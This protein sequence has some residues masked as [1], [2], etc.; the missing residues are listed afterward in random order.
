MTGTGRT[1]EERYF[2]GAELYGDDLTGDGLEAWFE[3]ER[4]GYADL[5]HGAGERPYEYHVLNDLHGWRHLPPGPLGDVL[6]VGSAFGLEFET[7]ADRLGTLTI[8]EPSAVLRSAAV[9]G[10]PVTYV[11]PR[12]SG[13]LTFA[14]GS[15]DLTVG[16]G[17]LHH[18]PNVSHVF[19][20]MVRV[21]RTGG[22]IVVREPIVSMGDWRRPRPGL[23]RHE[24]GLPLPWFRSLIAAQDVRVVHEGLCMFPVTR[25]LHGYNSPVAVRLD[26]AV[27]RLVAPN[28]TYHARSRWQKV[29]PGSLF[30]VLEKTGAGGARDG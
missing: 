18:I 20:E 30:V 24:R 1:F 16:L 12:S 3:D 26:A 25:R 15:F 21:T 7:L 27:S 9:D 6:G 8:L 23:T 13:T 14:Q 29:R 11:A 4:E 2:G 22:H 28:Y 19:A 5:D 17:V 10:V